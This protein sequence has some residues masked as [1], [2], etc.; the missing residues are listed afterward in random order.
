MN[1]E[2][3][4]AAAVD[5]TVAPRFAAIEA[6]LVELLE[7]PREP[8]LDRRGAAAWA[9]CSTRTVDAWLAEGA[10]HVRLGGP[11]GAPRFLASE[12]LAWLRRRGCGEGLQLVS[13]GAC[14]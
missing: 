11:G 10:P 7:R 9:G 12:L 1:I 6:L 3:A 14:R 2:A 8:L 13:G 4:L 5:A